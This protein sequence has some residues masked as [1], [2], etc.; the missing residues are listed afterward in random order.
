MSPKKKKNAGRTVL[1]VLLALVLIGA[2]VA[3]AAYFGLKNYNNAYKPGTE[4]FIEVEIEAGSGTTKIGKVLEDAGI[5]RS[6]QIFKFKTKFCGLD[7]K[8]QAGIYRLSPSMTMEKIMESLQNGKLPEVSFTIPEA[9]TLKQVGEKLVEDGIVSS[10]KDFLKALE[11]DYNYEFI[12]S[13]GYA[14]GEISAK[15]NRLEGYLYPET[16][17]IVE[18]ADAHT[19]IN[20]MLS[21]FKV[22]V[23]DKLKSKVPS[24][25]TF[26]DMVTLASIIEEECGAEKDRKTIS[27]VFWNRLNLPMRLQSDVT[28][29]YAL[30]DAPFSTKFDSPYNTY[31]VDG[32]PA[33]PIC[34]PAYNSIEAAMN[35]EHHNYYYFVLKGDRTGECNFAVTYEEHLANVAIYDASPYDY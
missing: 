13:K 17:R 8:Y 9:Y 20:T 10:M 28:I 5:I 25:Y 12:P 29:I 35:P 14:V 32:L 21:Y 18:G 3:A 31:L 7:G 26:H 19:V 15:A 2:G 6:A 23:Y 33:G 22:H 27:G 30:G 11:D 4:E 24:G 16:Y 34:S 1:K